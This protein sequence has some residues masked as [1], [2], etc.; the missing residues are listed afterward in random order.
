M[1]RLGY[2][3]NYFTRRAE[4][5]SS[6]FFFCLCIC[7]IKGKIL[8]INI[9]EQKQKEEGIVCLHKR[10]VSKVSKIALFMANHHLIYIRWIFRTGKKKKILNK[11]QSWSQKTHKK[12]HE[13]QTPALMKQ[14]RTH[15]ERDP[16]QG[17]WEEEGYGGR[18]SRAGS[19]SWNGDTQASPRSRRW[20]RTE[21][22]NDRE[23]A[24]GSIEGVSGLCD[25]FSGD[26]AT[27]GL[28][29]GL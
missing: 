23:T 12:E 19:S 15:L 18:R 6:Y 17:E 7:S 29:C 13:S 22:E 3:T 27:P 9:F 25:G 8:W 14:Q 21:M 10:I 5:Q 2:N 11:G 28:S 1:V 4:L 16:R 20:I 26:E 24:E